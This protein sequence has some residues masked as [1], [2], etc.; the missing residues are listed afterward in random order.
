[1]L[2]TNGTL[3]GCSLRKL[4]GHSLR[5]AQMTAMRTDRLTHGLLGRGLYLL[6]RAGNQKQVFS[7]NDKVDINRQLAFKLR[8]NP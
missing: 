3:G 7:V 5:P 2:V 6:P 8:R 1:M 4:G